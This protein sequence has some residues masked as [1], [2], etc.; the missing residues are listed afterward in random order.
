VGKALQSARELVLVNGPSHPASEQRTRTLVRVSGVV[1]ILALAAMW[2][3]AAWLWQHLPERIPLHFD[4]V[5]RPDRWG[6]TTA[7]GWFGLPITFT[8][9]SVFVIGAGA[10]VKMLETRRPGTV[11]MP[12]K[13]DFAALPT[14]ARARA[15]RPILALGLAMPVVFAVIVI[16]LQ[17]SMYASATNPDAPPSGLVAV[18]IATVASLVW[19]GI[20]LYLSARC[21]RAEA[22]AAQR[23]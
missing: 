13:K 4:L 22:A 12:L 5:G 9:L 3:H 8:V 19:V 10:L 7:L 14:E 17:R 21:V 2:A 15:M 11:N 6:E 23:E 16:D 1:G 18:W 20:C